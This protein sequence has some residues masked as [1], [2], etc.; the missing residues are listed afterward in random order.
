MTLHY[1]LGNVGHRI[2]LLSS[3]IGCPHD[4]YQRYQ[5][6]MS[7]VQN[8]NNPDLFITMTCN[9]NWEEIKSGLLSGYT[10]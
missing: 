5:D 3:F 1:K 4:I 10:P 6:A 7:L 9:P 8:F 2:I